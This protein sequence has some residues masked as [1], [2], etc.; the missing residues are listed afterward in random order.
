MRVFILEKTFIYIS[1]K[2][3][4]KSIRPLNITPFNKQKKCTQI[5]KSFPLKIRLQ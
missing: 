3:N 2:K 4:L 1:L 5:L